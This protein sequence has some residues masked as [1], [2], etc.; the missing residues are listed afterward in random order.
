MS[1]NDTNNVEIDPVDT[2]QATDTQSD[3]VETSPVSDVDRNED[4]EE[5]SQSAPQDTQEGKP[6]S[7]K[8]EEAA[9]REEGKLQQVQRELAQER[10]RIKNL[11]TWI[12][13]DPDLLEKALVSTSG[14]EPAQAKQVADQLRA[15][16]AQIQQ[17]NQVNQYQ[18]P[19]QQYQD[20]RQI[21]ALVYQ[22]VKQEEADKEVFQ[23]L[24]QAYPEL[25]E[26][27]NDVA[28]KTTT[29]PYEEAEQRKMNIQRAQ[30]IATAKMQAIPGI[31]YKDAM[32]SAYSEITGKTAQQVQQAREDGKL[33]G[34]A[35]SNTAQSAK[36]TPSI[37]QPS[38]TES[39]NL[40]DFDR[41]M[42][43]KFDM[44]EKEWFDMGKT[45][46]TTVN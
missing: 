6:D 36:S 32:I 34:L 40:S 33:E 23:A 39:Y 3:I 45:S 4:S 17:A 20:P 9:R 46:S 15:Q 8:A 42:A 5:S 19:Q 7:A 30:Y 10:E 27:A 12:A 44:T 14:Y 1:E 28:N 41:T 22:Q 29:V 2:Q 25:Q 13:Q 43:K 26:L 16:Q 37:T 35:M 18:Q 38:R 31:S 21:A 24:N 11:S